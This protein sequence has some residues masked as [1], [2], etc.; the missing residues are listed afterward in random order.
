M[1]ERFL[2]ILPEKMIVFCTLVTFLVPYLIYKLNQKLH[3]KGDPPWKKE[4]G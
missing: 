3:K 4:D 1:W 2:G